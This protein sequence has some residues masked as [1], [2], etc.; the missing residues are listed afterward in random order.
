[1]K[2]R[3]IKPKLISVVVKEISTNKIIIAFPPTK[4]GEQRAEKY[5]G[6]ADLEIIKR[7]E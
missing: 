7:Y 6:L 1:M 5:R 4:A 3:E 2:R